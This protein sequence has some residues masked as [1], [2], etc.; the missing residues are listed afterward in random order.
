MGTS[1]RWRCCS[2]WV[3]V[4]LLSGT[5][6]GREVPRTLSLLNWPR[7]KILSQ[8]KAPIESQPYRTFRKLK[9][10][11]SLLSAVERTFALTTGMSLSFIANNLPR[12][13]NTSTLSSDCPYA[14]NDTFRAQAEFT[15]ACWRTFLSVAS[16]QYCDVVCVVLSAR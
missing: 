14:V 11:C 5:Q 6:N 8:T 1:I 13:L 10:T 2:F 15:A 16:L 7:L 3:C 4:S 9:V 12:Y